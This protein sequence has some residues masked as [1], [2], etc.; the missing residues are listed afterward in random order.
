M[1]KY[2]PRCGSSNIEW[3]IPQDW[4]RWR[5]RECGYIGALIVEDGEL[6]EEIRK[7]RHTGEGGCDSD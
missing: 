4:S 2:C 6:A 1:V 5:C 7:A 3:I